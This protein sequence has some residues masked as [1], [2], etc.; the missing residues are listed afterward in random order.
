VIGSRAA[1]DYL[2]EHVGPE[3]VDYDVLDRTTSSRHIMVS[4]RGVEGKTIGDMHFI[5]KHQCYL[6]QV[7][8][9]GI[10]M[11]RRRDLELQMGDVLVLTGPGSQLSALAEDLGYSETLLEQTDLVAFTFGIAVGVV[12]GMFSVTLGGVKIGLGTAGGSMLAG[13]LFGILHARKPNIAR[14]PA[15]ARNIL[16]ELGLLLFMANVAVSAGTNIVETIKSA[17]PMLALAGVFITLTPVVVC[18]FVGRYVFKMNGAILMGS[19]TGAMTSTPALTQVTKLARSS[20]P[21]LGYVGTYAFANVLLA[22]AGTIV[23]LL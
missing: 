1:H 3:I 17:G 9:S 16:M 6:T 4:S 2:R 20:V 7:I 21:T 19:L 23:M 11:P 5:S 10:D 18:F 15:A 8:R 14:F 12:I 22:I 13:L